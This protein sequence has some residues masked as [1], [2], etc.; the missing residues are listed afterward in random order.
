MLLLVPMYLFNKKADLREK[1]VRVLITAFLLISLNTNY[2]TYIWHGFHF[3]NGLPGR[4]SFIYIFMLL[5]MGYE[6]IGAGNPVRNGG[7]AA[8]GRLAWIP[9][10]FLVER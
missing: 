1:I 6:A 3:P 7:G 9:W 10:I 8:G 4:F 2:L 5:L